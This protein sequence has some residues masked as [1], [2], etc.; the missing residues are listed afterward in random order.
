MIKTLATFNVNDYVLVK[1]TPVGKDLLK[2]NDR[3]IPDENSEGW[4]RWQLW[5]LASAFGDHMYNGC[6]IPFE[7]SI[8]FEHIANADKVDALRHKLRAEM[9]RIYNSM[10]KRSEMHDRM[11]R[12][13][14]LIEIQSWHELERSGTP[15]EVDDIIK[16]SGEIAS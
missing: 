12:T 11:S 10:I 9:N 13:M 1:L 16:E 5:E 8:Q 4:S 14:T 6:Q 3:P 2:K 15:E 7:T